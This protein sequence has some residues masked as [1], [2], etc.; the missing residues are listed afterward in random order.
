MSTVDEAVRARVRSDV[1]KRW[2]LGDFFVPKHRYIDAEFLELEIE[3]VFPRTWLVACRLEE[4]AEVGD[5]VE[6][7]PA[8]ESI[9]V[10][11]ET[12]DR[13]RAFFN[14]CRHRGARLARHRGRVGNLR[15]PFHAWQYGLDG[16]NQYVHDHSDFSELAADYLCLRQCRVGT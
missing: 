15:C 9:V 8:G 10:I 11:R 4:L 6:F 1:P 5:Y 2:R 3:R 16:T 12:D 13:V 14:S 7:S